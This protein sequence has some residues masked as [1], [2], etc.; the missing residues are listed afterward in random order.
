MMMG[1]ETF[2]CEHLEGKDANE[3]LKVLRRLKRENTA[4]KRRIENPNYSPKHAVKPDEKAIIW[5]NRLYVD[6]C[7]E[8]LEQLGVTYVPTKAETKAAEVE[9]KLEHVEK[10]KLEIRGFLTGFTTWTLAVNGDSV[11][12]EKEGI[13]PKPMYEKIEDY[14][15]REELLLCLRELY[16]GEWKRRYDAYD[17]GCCIMDGE[18]WTLTVYVGK[19]SKPI[20]FEGC[21]AYPYNW[22]DVL[23][24]V[25]RE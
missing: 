17:Y 23:D 12:L 10:V 5:A 2:Y 11:S 3:V 20:V 4:L 18:Q 13:L 6:R 9:A 7:K 14:I 8:A 22:D 15:D 19:D 1:P 24:L 25:N 21:N 16:L